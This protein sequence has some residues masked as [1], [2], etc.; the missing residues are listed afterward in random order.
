MYNILSDLVVGGSVKNTCPC[1]AK[2]GSA[3]KNTSQ[4]FWELQQLS[5]TTSECVEDPSRPEGAPCSSGILIELISDFAETHAADKPVA[6]IKSDLLPKANTEEAEAVKQAAAV[7]GCKSESCVVSHPQFIGFASKAKGVSPV[8]ISEKKEE[9]FKAA[10]PRNSTALLTDSNIDETLQKWTLSF[11]EFFAYPFAMMDFDRTKEDFASIDV[12]DV[13]EGRVVQKMRIGEPRKP[14]KCKFLAC[15]LNTD[16]S[17][18]PGLHWVAAVIDA[19]SDTDPWSVEYFNS[20]GR[21]PPK[22]VVVWMERTRKRLETYRA[23]KGMKSN[24]VIC[25]PVTS[26]AHQD[27]QT[28]CGLYSLYYIRKRLEGSP[29]TFFMGNVITDEAMTQ[30]RKHVF[31]DRE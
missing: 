4:D 2:K 21:P 25:V 31:R 22:P 27:S 28:E 11:P 26:I 8:V 17:T 13:L 18:G 9:V 16:V 14:R 15:V 7:L 20:A 5:L 24:G 10:G 23:R 6:E 1:T 12:V 29:Y 19:R 3:V 30:F